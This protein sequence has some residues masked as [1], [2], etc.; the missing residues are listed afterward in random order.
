MKKLWILML[1]VLMALSLV[2]VVGCQKKEEA[3]APAV[4]AP[5]PEA[6]AVE[7]P[8]PEAPAPAAEA[9]APAPAP[10]K[11]AP[12]KKSAGGY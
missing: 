7:A 5:A 12:A 9:P 8:A 10:E 4:E 3:P 2:L 11:P 1:T 6:P